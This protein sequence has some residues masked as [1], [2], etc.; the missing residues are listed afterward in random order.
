MCLSVALGACGRREQS[1]APSGRL[2]A[3]YHDPVGTGGALTLM[4]YE[5]GAFLLYR[6]TVPGHDPAAP[7]ALVAEGT[8][9]REESVL[10]LETSDWEAV[11][12]SASVPVEF[13]DEPDTL[14]GLQW[15]QSTSE[16]PADSS[17][18]VL[19]S[20]FA[21][22]IYPLEGSGKKQAGW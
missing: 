15:M 13:R 22:L 2:L 18:F 4:L 10:V 11:F 6:C 8:W 12:V 21:D 1:R 16:T 20:D 3:E 9:A 5:G 19:R 7:S 17:R 14:R